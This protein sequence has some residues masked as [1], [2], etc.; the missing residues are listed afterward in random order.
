MFFKRPQKPVMATAAVHRFACAGP[1][2]PDTCCAGWTIEVDR[3][4]KRKY[5][6]KYDLKDAYEPF[7]E[8]EHAM[9]CEGKGRLCVMNRDGWC[10]IQQRY[11]EEFLSDSC[12]YFPRT[13]RQLG[14]HRMA[15]LSL[16]CPE[17]ARLTLF[18]PWDATRSA[19]AMGRGMEITGNRL[20][21]PCAEEAA[22][23]LHHAIVTA[24]EDRACSAAQHLARLVLLCDA[25]ETAPPAEWQGIAQQMLA[26]PPP[27]PSDNRQTGDEERLMQ[28]LLRIA[29]A[30]G[31][32]YRDRLYHTL[33]DMEKALA[34]P[35]HW[36]EGTVE[37]ADAP[38]AAALRAS[39]AQHGGAL[40]EPLRQWLAAYLANWVF[41]FAGPAQDPRDQAFLLCMHFA[42]T[43][44]A[45]Q[46]LTHL[47]AA[48]P[49]QAEILRAVQSI[50]RLFDH[51]TDAQVFFRA[52]DYAG[53]THEHRLRALFGG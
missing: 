38:Y 34:A 5:D 32:Q 6:R 23:A 27:P 40:E 47:H 53:W 46:C 43:R 8:G 7:G 48:P 1:E 35:L 20:P 31:S 10:G 28:S 24:M 51:I 2:C 9:R 16:A 21:K 30:D 25:L 42:V 17:A 11:G 12:Y 39:W 26:A 13:Y 50:A 45:L 37:H 14:S 49:P 19:Y 15:G 33:R 4:T 3:I 44:L 36:T 41:P 29:I 18:E 52:F 22:L